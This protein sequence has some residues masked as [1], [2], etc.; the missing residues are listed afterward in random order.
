MKVKNL[1]LGI[2]IF[3]VFMFLLHNGIR[4]F[5]P[6]PQYEDF[7]DSNRWYNTKPIL[8]GGNCTY[9]ENLRQQEQACYNQKGQ[10]IYDY[11]NFGC[12]VSVTECDLCQVQYDD[13]RESFNKMVFIVSLIVGI[14]ILLVGYLVLSIEP[15][16]SALMASGIGAIVYGTISN[17]ENLGTLGRFL[18]LLLAFILLIWIAIS[19]NSE[20]KFFGFKK[21]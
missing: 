11:D 14:L 9:S 4:V 8:A 16:G 3:L 18:L 1:V 15:V 2:G 19:L 5:S 17:W 21:K 6:S 13:A 10:P 20:R 7:C 12:Q